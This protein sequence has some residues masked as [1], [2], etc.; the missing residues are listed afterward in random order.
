MS[1]ASS[2]P[3]PLALPTVDDDW[4]GWLQDRGKGGIERAREIA[5]ALRAEPG[6]SALTLWN[7]LR[8]ELSNTFA[9]CSLLSQVHPDACV[10]CLAEEIELMASVFDTSLRLDRAP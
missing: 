10:R 6:G 4:S 9:V 8:I 7:D 5:D 2:Q 3:V 1:A